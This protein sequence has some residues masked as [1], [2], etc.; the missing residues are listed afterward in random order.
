M[1]VRIVNR[2]TGLL[3]GR[4]WPDVGEVLEV[5]DSVGADMCSAGIGTPEVDDKVEKAVPP[6][7]EQRS[8]D[9]A[10]KG[11]ASRDEWAAYAASKGAPDEETQPVEDGGLGRDD[12][13][14]KY[15]S[16]TQAQAGSAEG[17]GEA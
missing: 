15:G 5:E 11:N 14:A 10:P 17:A 3:N 9:E 1:K 4:D 6:A 12:L 16:D 2:P 7:T 13:R 8:G